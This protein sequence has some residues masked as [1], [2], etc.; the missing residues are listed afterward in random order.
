[1]SRVTNKR[2]VSSEP[3]ERILVVDDDAGVLGSVEAV[4]RDEGFDVVTVGGGREAIAA[5]QRWSP[6]LVLL[7]V[8]MPDL[9]G[10]EVLERIREGH[11][12][13]PVDSGPSTSSRSRFR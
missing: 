12:D 6:A 3:G 7:D 4:L 13:L 8:W 10:I 9:D 5:V 2:A 1:M 11:K